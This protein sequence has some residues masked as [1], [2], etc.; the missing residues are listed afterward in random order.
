MIGKVFESNSVAADRMTQGP[1]CGEKNAY[2]DRVI[3]GTQAAHAFFPGVRNLPDNEIVLILE[4]LHLLL[5]KL[6]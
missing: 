5:E 1:H 2:A 4:T 6:N 3:L